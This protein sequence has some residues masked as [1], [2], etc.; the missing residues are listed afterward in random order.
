MTET[1]KDAYGCELT[2]EDL[3]A[4]L[5]EFGLYIDV[6]IGDLKIIYSLAQEKARQR[7]REQGKQEKTTK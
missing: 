4:A 2:D 7:K 5:K 3:L 1:G 6:T